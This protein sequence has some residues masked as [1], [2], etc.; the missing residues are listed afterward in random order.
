MS[1]FRNPWLCMPF[2]QGPLCP[3]TGAWMEQYQNRDNCPPP[4]WAH[5][6]KGGYGGPWNHKGLNCILTWGLSPQA[7]SSPWAI[8]QPLG[9]CQHIS[10]L[11]LG[12]Q[13]GTGVS[14]LNVQGL[15][16]AKVLL[17]GLS[18]F[19]LSFRNTDQG[20]K[21]G[22]A[23]VW[24]EASVGW[25]SSKLS[26]SISAFYCVRWVINWLAHRSLERVKWCFWKILCMG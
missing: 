20:R 26:V 7:E 22:K 12:T 4:P 9:K 13:E 5:T 17:P 23:V 24:G 10:C 1:C 18:C 8:L 6:H 11:F 2:S 3:L 25:P 16:G 19:Y 14:N 21:G 15:A